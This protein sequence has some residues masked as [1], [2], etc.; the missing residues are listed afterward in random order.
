MNEAQFKKLYEAFQSLLTEEIINIAAARVEPVAQV[1]AGVERRLTAVESRPVPVDPTPLIQ[2]LRDLLAVL[3]GR[4]LDL[5]K[6]RPQPAP[7]PAPTPAPTPTPPAAGPTIEAWPIGPALIRGIKFDGGKVVVDAE[8]NVIVNFIGTGCPVHD[9]AAPYEYTR[10]NEKELAV[11]AWNGST[12]D[13]RLIRF[14]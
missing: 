2:P 12:A 13:A 5:E 9:A 7:Q 11:W 14:A 8:P 6:T 10:R 3:E 4:V 1:L